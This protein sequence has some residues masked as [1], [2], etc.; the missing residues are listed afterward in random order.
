MPYVSD[1]AS[2]QNV[3]KDNALEGHV[4][5][6]HEI[7]KI[8]SIVVSS[9]KEL[10]KTDAV[11][12]YFEKSAVGGPLESDIVKRTAEGFLILDFKDEQSKFIMQQIIT[13]YRCPSGSNRKTLIV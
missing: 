5:S 6:I 10:D 9:D 13:Y 7:P 2:L 11:I 4:L 12:F 3:I 8:K 1:L